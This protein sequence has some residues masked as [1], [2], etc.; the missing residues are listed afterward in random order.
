MIRLEG[1]PELQRNL[2]EIVRQ[3]PDATRTEMLDGAETLR[4]RVANLVRRAPGS[5]DI[6]DHIDINTDG[7]NV[8]LGP[9]T[10]ERG[11]QPGRQFDEQGRMLEYGT[12]YMP[13][14]PFMRPVFESEGESTSRDIVTRVWQ[15]LTGWL[16]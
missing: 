1:V 11:D 16:P 14:F 7:E 2:R 6:A 3:A 12:R 5:P 15:R 9:S 4:Q 13:A 8:V 10:D